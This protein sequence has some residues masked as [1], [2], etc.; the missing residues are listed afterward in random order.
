[1]TIGGPILFIMTFLFLSFGP[2]SPIQL[3]LFIGSAMMIFMLGI[4]GSRSFKN[5][6]L[7]PHYCIGWYLLL[8]L[9]IGCYLWFLYVAG[10][11]ISSPDT[12]PMQQWWNDPTNIANVGI[13]E[14]YHQ[15]CGWS[16]LDTTKYCTY[17]TSCKNFFVNNI[18]FITICYSS[19]ATIWTLITILYWS[20][21]YKGRNNGGYVLTHVV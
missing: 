20:S 3:T 19:G 16:T 2:L 4:I 12:C 17:Q 5:T 14:S 10:V 6:S 8:A 7:V 13:R 15:C 18:D 21:N 9:Q 11:I 1:M